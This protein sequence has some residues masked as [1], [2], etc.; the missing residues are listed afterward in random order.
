[1]SA[2]DRGRLIWDNVVPLAPSVGND[3]DMLS[4]YHASGH[5][6][7]S[8]TIAGDDCGLATA[9]HRLAQTKRLIRE[10]PEKLLLTT[11]VADV[12]RARKERKLGVGL[13][14]ESTECLE[15][16]PDMVDLM[17]E[18]GIRHSILA[19]N[20]NNSAA[21][22]CADLGEVGLSRLGRRYVGRMRDVGMLLDLSHMSVRSTLEAIE[23]IERPVVF[24]HSN[25]HALHPHYRNVTDEQARACAQSGGLV[26]ISGSSAYI[27]E[28]PSL[29]E[30]V[31]R[32]LDYLVQLIGPAHVGIGTDYVA[33]ADAIVRIFAARADEWPTDDVVSYDRVNYLPPEDLRLVVARMEQAGYDEATI[34]RILDGNYLRI[35]GAV[36][37]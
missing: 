7:V 16:D 22:G 23:L 31:F 9:L 32:H 36:W 3:F 33:D 5:T 13:H 30:G 20:Q 28:A 34:Q 2:G 27:G 1:M 24:T 11:S 25:V 18:L 26:G 6:V 35:A 8:L 10:Q 29:V 21:G 14:L 12:L 17:Y 15:R 37:R 4:R 19:F